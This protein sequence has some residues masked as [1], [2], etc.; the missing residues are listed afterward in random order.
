M[1]LSSVIFL[2]TFRV[3]SKHAKVD[4]RNIQILINSRVMPLADHD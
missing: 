4:K 3:L 2:L 1:Q